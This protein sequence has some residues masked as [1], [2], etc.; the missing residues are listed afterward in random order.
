MRSASLGSAQVGRR[1]ARA[2]L[3]LV[4]MTLGGAMTLG[5]CKQESRTEIIVGVATDLRAPAPLYQVQLTAYRL[6][7]TDK[8]IADQQFMISGRATLEYGLPGTYAVYSDQGK[9]DR[10]RVVLVATDDN[11]QVVVQR[12]AVLNLVPGKTLFVRMGVV[13]AC[14]GKLDC[15]AGD[16]CIDG[17]CAPE[18]IDSSRLPEYSPG[19]ENQVACSGS[20][21]FID[22]GTNQPLA[23]TG[24]ACP[25]NGWCQD[26]MCLT[27]SPFA[28]TKGVPTAVRTGASQVGST[29]TTLTDG[30]V[31][32]VGGV[33][34]NGAPVLAS[35][36]TYDP[37][38]QTFTAAGSL[39]TP[40]VYFGEARL[41]NGRV[42][43]AGGINEG[44]A[45]LAT[46][47]LY[48]PVTRKFTP[49]HV[50]MNEARVFPGLVT[51]T[52]G[53]VLVVGGINDVQGYAAGTVHFFDGLASAEIYD[54]AT[55][56]FTPSGSLTEGRGFPH[57]TAQ[58]GGGALVI[59]G[60]FMNTP[61]T[62]LERFDPAT[63]TFVAATPATLPAGE[64]G[65]SSDVAELPDGRLLVTMTTTNDVWLLD[66]VAGKFTQAAVPPLTPSGTLV[67]V[68]GGGQVLYAGAGPQNDGAYV[69]DPTS[70]GFSIVT[71]NMTA[72]R[73]LLMGAALPNGDALIVG[74]G[75]A[76]AEIYKAPVMS[77][78]GD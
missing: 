76:S 61:R 46:A 77:V 59:G 9:P 45:A 33:G 23:A 43:I 18:E 19:M 42:L 35:A 56:T 32:L 58:P 51:L 2:P 30:S 70:G 55:D 67:G 39:S 68:L 73:P 40:R 34:M 69:Y 15:P 16:T 71:A 64:S 75:M 78:V 28:A 8:V 66:P 62:S 74:A 41:P 25:N 20:V 31:L 17:R 72:G 53:R 12:T 10:V 22:T 6:P 21:N 48:D 63:G 57:V 29:L 7:G 4:A 60:T 14:M 38:A 36:E 47:E 49:T 24:T 27:G 50:P 54:P 3:L 1:P 26:G 5:A 37:V 52:D 65:C 44:Q 13:S 11:Q